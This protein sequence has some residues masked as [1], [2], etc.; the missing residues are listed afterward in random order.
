MSL[1]AVVGSLLLASLPLLSI[2]EPA[3]DAAKAFGARPSVEDLS[4][5]PDGLSVAFVAPATGQGSVVYV[6]NLAKGATRT[7]EAVLGAKAMPSCAGSWECRPPRI[8]RSRIWRCQ[9]RRCRA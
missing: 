4:L 5:S 7:L 3:F 9:I 8:W 1:R 6:Q 2:A